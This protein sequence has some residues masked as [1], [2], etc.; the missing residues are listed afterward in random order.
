MTIP[1][2]DGGTVNQIGQRYQAFYDIGQIGLQA[3]AAFRSS[4]KWNPQWPSDPQ[5]TDPLLVLLH[6]QAALTHPR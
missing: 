6:W 1:G 3:A 2:E 5:N 4:G